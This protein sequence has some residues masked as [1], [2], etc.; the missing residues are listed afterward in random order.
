[1]DVVICLINYENIMCHSL[2]CPL[3]NETSSNEELLHKL[4]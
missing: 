3:I 4:F 1:V 2:F